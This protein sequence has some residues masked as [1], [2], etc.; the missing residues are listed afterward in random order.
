[1][2]QLA[3]LLSLLMVAHGVGTLRTIRACERQMAIEFAILKKAGVDQL[4]TFSFVERLAMQLRIFLD[5]AEAQKQIRERHVL[6]ASS[7]GIQGVILETARQLGFEDE[8]KGLFSDYAV[9]ALR[10]DYFCRV[11]D[12]GILLEVERGKTIANNMDLLDLWKCHIC[13]HA[14]YLFLVVPQTRP[15]A[16]GSL[17]RQFSHVQKRL[18]PFFHPVNYVNVEAVFLFGY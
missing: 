6:G 12:T 18:A 5:E 4:G 13:A 14:S 8:R 2:G 15:S 10:P 9:S 11:G 1:M 3:K 7:I 17:I 16:N